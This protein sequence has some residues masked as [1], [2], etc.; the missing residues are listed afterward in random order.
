LDG[1]NSQLLASLSSV[2]VGL[3]YWSLNRNIAALDKE[4]GKLA[5]DSEDCAEDI[6]SIRERV[7][8]L[9]EHSKTRR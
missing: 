1:I 7:I 8:I 3:L 2:I 5:E 6:T 9:E 4:I